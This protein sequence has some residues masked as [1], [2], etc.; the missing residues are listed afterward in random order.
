MDDRV[1]IYK[2]NDVA[3]LVRHYVLETRLLGFDIIII[4]DTYLAIGIPRGRDVK[5]PNKAI[6]FYEMP[7]LVDDF[8]DWHKDV[9][10]NTTGIKP[11]SEWREERQSRSI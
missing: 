11:Y 8:K 6:I 10:M 2:R 1:N 9:L 3:D 7:D 5:D 4:D